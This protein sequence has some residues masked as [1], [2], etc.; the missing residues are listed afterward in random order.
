LSKMVAEFETHIQAK[1]EPTKREQAILAFL[2][3]YAVP[4]FT[5]NKI[6]EV[7]AAEISR[8]FDWRKVNSKK[9]APRE[10]TILHETSMLSTFLNWAFKRGLLHRKIELENPKIEADR[11]PHFDTKDWAKLTRFLREWVK[12]GVNKSGPIYRDRLMLTNYL[13]I[14]ANTGIR[15]GEA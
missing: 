8:F 5:R 12:Q 15:V 9:K 10:T 7:T 14:L 3:T 13:L 2:R 4:Y 6:T 11:R 1:G